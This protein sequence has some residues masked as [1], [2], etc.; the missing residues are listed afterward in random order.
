MS[1]LQELLEFWLRIQRGME[2]DVMR[3]Q[4]SIRK[5]AALTQD[6]KHIGIL[7]DVLITEVCFF[8]VISHWRGTVAVGGRLHELM[9]HYHTV[10]LLIP[11]DFDSIFCLYIYRQVLQSGNLPVLF[12][13]S[14]QKSTFWPLAE[15][16]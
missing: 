6:L 10:L 12:L 14:S 7:L 11:T 13:L 2:A 1:C 15:K 8:P 9:I 5:V 4:D 16:I 3:F